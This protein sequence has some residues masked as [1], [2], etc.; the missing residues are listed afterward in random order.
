MT[1]GARGGEAFPRVFGVDADPAPLD[2]LLHH[3][4]VVGLDPDSRLA[5]VSAFA[6]RLFARVKAPAKVSRGS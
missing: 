2:R 1:I 4:R 6:A 3:A 5:E